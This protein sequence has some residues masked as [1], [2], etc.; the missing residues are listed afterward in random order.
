MAT[1]TLL[2]VPG[3]PSPCEWQPLAVLSL[4]A[5]LPHP[6]L[7]QKG[8]GSEWGDG[9]AEGHAGSRRSQ[10][11]PPPRFRIL[12]LLHGPPR[13]SPLQGSFL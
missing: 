12:F 5:G 3:A 2:M 4:Q 6:E 8:P 1:G 9:G 10:R 13:P 7:S 11:P